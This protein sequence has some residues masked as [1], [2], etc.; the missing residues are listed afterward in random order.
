MLANHTTVIALAAGPPTIL[1]A[2][3]SVSTTKAMSSTCVHVIPVFQERC[4]SSGGDSLELSVPAGAQPCPGS[5]AG[6]AC[7]SATDQTEP[8][9]AST[10]D[11]ASACPT[12]P[13]KPVLSSPAACTDTQLPIEAALTDESSKRVSTNAPVVV[14][15]V[16]VSSL[17][18]G[19]VQRLTLS[20]S[21]NAVQPGQ[22]VVLTA[23]STLNVKD[24]DTAIEI[25]D[26]TTGTLAGACTQG[27]QCIVS[28]TAN[29]G[30]HSFAAY[31]TKPTSRM[32]SDGS[33]LMS[34]P[35]AVGWVGVTLSSKS[36]VVGPGKAITVTASSTVPIDKSGN[37]LQL[38]DASTKS[39]LSY[40]SQGT[41]C[42]L[43]M[44]QPASG[45][46]SVVAALGKSSSTFPP[47]VTQAQSDPV[48]V[49][50]LSVT[51]DGSSTFQ[52]GG[53]VYLNATS[54]ADLS[55]TP[56]SI[57]IF[58]DQG[59]LVAAPCK[60]GTTCST[61]ISL[62]TGATP[63]YSAAIG[64]VPPPDTSS[65]LGQL[66]HKVTG[67]SSLVSIQAR[68][69]S[70]Q[71]TRMLWGV[72]SCKSFTDDPTAGNGL[73]PQVV[74]SL[75]PPDFWGRYLTNTVCP[76]ISGAE[77]SA[78]HSKHMG[79]LPIYN[80]YNCSNVVGYDTAM[81]YATA[82]VAAARSLGIPEGRGLAIDIE[83][84]GDACPGAANIDTGFIQGW[85]DGMK[86]GHYIPIFYGNGTAGSEFGSQW[87]VAV[88]AMPEIANEGYVWS[89]EPSLLGNYNKGSAPYY[90]PNT[91]GCPG[92]AS[93]WQYQ[94]SAGSN[95][96]VD[97][98]EAVSDLPL[99]FP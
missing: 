35:I 3:R 67:P 16:P 60:S 43:S 26:Q 42:S 31:L 93:A 11:G 68:S 82:A 90:S 79:I 64:V 25:F 73:Y 91:T 57:G 12:A 7:G 4:G 36:P 83:P 98:D 40:C 80:D 88:T 32:P 58:D 41:T 84:P 66:L 97:H 69:A 30:I 74:S 96:D 62:P 51:L 19:S 71:P 53:A 61:Q 34:N 81:G 17:Q 18:T 10:P 72:D 14:P 59:H 89:F 39:R 23:T 47:P 50:W 9:V 38:F 8:G 49:T 5:G 95:P 6:A 63:H 85:F 78:A 54:N 33:G 76:G 27:S 55:N 45:V 65:K 52:L 92:H 94:I 22:G 1:A 15:S 99:W 21:A 37:L 24:V 46:R 44:I 56:Y 20:G 48:S 70:V 28:Y 75:G 86:D 13:D 2:A 87:C 77:I 29:S